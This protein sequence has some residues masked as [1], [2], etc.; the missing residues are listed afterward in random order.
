MSAEVGFVYAMINGSFE[1]QV[2]VGCSISHPNERA[3][4][5]SASTSVPTTFVVAFYRRVRNPFQ[6][7]A[8]LHRVLKDFRVN[9]SREFFTAPLHKI[10]EMIEKYDEVVGVVGDLPF[11]ELFASFPDD[12]E[13]RELTTEEQTKCRALEAALSR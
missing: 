3:R 12:G 2:K 4:Q 13:P 9:D 6:V 7:E 8:A 10:V 11:S 5:L 1:G